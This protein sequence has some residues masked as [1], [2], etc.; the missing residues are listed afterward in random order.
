MMR[1][2]YFVCTSIICTHVQCTNLNLLQS[3]QCKLKLCYANY[4][5][6]VTVSKFQAYG[7]DAV[8]R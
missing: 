7:A 1:D 5:I 2:N 8:L 3:R 6:L 4:L